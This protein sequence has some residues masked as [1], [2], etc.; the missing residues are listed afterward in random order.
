MINSQCVFA[1]AFCIYTQ[2]LA[3]CLDLCRPSFSPY[4][5]IVRQFQSGYLFVSYLSFPQLGWRTLQFGVNFDLLWYTSY[6]Y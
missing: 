4:F 5:V 1:P 6:L 2:I 3:L